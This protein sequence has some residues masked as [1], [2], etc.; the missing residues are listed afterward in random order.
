MPLFEYHCEK[1]SEDHELLVRGTEKPVCPGCG[2]DRLTKQ[3]SAF[4]AVTAPTRAPASSCAS[5][6]QRG[7]GSC[8]YN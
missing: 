1:C 3:A 2:S 4:A 8:P 7:D 5:C 6:C